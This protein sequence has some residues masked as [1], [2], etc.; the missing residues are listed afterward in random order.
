LGDSAHTRENAVNFFKQ[1]SVAFS[2]STPTLRADLHD[3][4]ARLSL[5]SAQ[6]FRLLS[7]FSS[8]E[9]TNGSIIFSSYLNFAHN[10]ITITPNN[11]N[12]NPREQGLTNS[13]R[14]D[15]YS[16]YVDAFARAHLLTHAKLD[17][18]IFASVRRRL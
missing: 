1:N 15:L 3:A 7:S 18:A 5:F 13:M 14:F 9:L 6:Q 2:A 17:A 12:L 16:N 11:F 8:S 4:G 10:N